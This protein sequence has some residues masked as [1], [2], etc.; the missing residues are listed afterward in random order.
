L[1]GATAVDVLVQITVIKI[2]IA[3]LF[4]L[5]QNSRGTEGNEGT[6]G[7]GTNKATRKEIYGVKDTGWGT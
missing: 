4:R 6:N 3:E 1:P 7:E 5:R 2:L